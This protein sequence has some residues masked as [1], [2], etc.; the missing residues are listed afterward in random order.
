MEYQWNN[1]RPGVWNRQSPGAALAV[2]CGC[3]LG[4]MEARAAMI[5]VP[6]NFPGIQAAINAAQNGDTVL[7]APGTHAGGLTITAKSIVLASPFVLTG[8][9]ADISRTT[10]SGG[11]PILKINSSAGA[12]TTVQG[13]TF[14]NGNYQIV[15]HAR[16]ISLLNNRFFGGSGD[17]VSFEAAGGVVRDCWFEDAAD[18]GVDSDDA[19]DPTIEANTILNARDDGIEVRLQPFTGP[20]RF[21][22]IRGNVISG[23]RE[24]G[25]QLIDYPGASNRVFWIEG[26]TI[27]NSAKAGLGCMA[28]GNTTE[29]FA[30]APLVE[31]VRVIGNTFVGNPH[32]LTGGDNML[33]MNNIFVGSAQIAVKRV[34]ASSVVTHNDFWNNGTDY[35]GSN[36]DVATALHVDP[37]LD[38]AHYP[39]M[40]S[41]CIDA[42]AESH[43][44]NGDAVMAPPYFGTAPDLGAYETSYPPSVSV[45]GGPGPAGLSIA[46]VRPNPTRAGFAVDFTL[47]DASPA[48]IELLDL[49]GRR[50]LMRQLDGLGPGSHVVSLPETR[51]LPAGVYILRLSQGD[52][53]RTVR[54]V[55]VR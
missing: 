37:L 8:D 22:V 9:T 5:H 1:K 46:R 23:C 54:T 44:W 16:R 40:G 13:L 30:G 36:V 51:A 7:V 50:V 34:A 41:P 39:L 49:A 4:A 48:R 14:R 19:S 21:I 24:D 20:P 26:N 15:N 35:T 43:L 55:L 18:D 45:G 11:S 28:N 31:R 3:S 12:S 38:A 52:R 29:N 6:G 53:S 17:Q 42:G 25:I 32:G 2:L 33:V 10:I 27:S 47:P